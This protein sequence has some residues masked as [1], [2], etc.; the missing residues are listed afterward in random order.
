MK[1]LISATPVFFLL[2]IALNC[3]S[4]TDEEQKAMMAYMTP[5]DVHQMLAKSAGNWSAAITMWMK[6][7][8]PPSMMTGEMKN[9]MILGGRYLQGTNTG[10]M[11]GM[12]FQGIGVTGYDNAKKIFVNSWI[13]NFGTGIMYMEGKW[14]A[15]NK[16][17]N[18]TGKM[19]DPATGKDVPIRETIKFID[20]NTQKFEMYAMD[21]GK[22]YKSMEIT[23]VRK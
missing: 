4:Q 21:Q 13:D 22:E 1:K 5:G 11:M 8:A 2:F 6:P 18:F 3:K 16:M 20:D 14:D 15:A 19:V 10:N 9:E 17:I 12:P 23:Y 7:G